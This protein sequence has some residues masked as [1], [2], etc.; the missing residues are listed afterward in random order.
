MTHLPIIGSKEVIVNCKD[1]CYSF[2]ATD[3]Q[4][5]IKREVFEMS[6][7]HEETDS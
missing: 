5:G 4:Q 1:V 6:V 2:T 3:D 7:S